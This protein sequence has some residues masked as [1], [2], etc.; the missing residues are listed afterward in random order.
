[1]DAEHESHQIH[2]VFWIRQSRGKEKCNSLDELRL[3]R[4]TRLALMQIYGAERGRTYCGGGALPF[5]GQD[6]GDAAAKLDE[7]EG[8]S[9]DGGGAPVPDGGERKKMQN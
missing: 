6:Q 5:S 3:Y 4:G 2:G 8:R 1:M 7:D 9:G